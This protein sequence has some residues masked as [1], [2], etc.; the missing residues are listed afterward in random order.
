M[1]YLKNKIN[2]K[3]EID[4]FIDSVRP[5]NQNKKGE[6]ALTFEDINKLLIGS[7]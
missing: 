4:K 3:D 6:N 2:L 7:S 5:K 1:M